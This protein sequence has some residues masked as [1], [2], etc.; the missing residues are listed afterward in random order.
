[1]IA[2][3]IQY[4]FSDMYPMI[5]NNTFLSIAGLILVY[6][7][8]I[9]SIYST[10]KKNNQLMRIAYFDSLT[11]LANRESLRSTIDG[12]TMELRKSKERKDIN[13]A[14]VM[15]KCENLDLIN[16]AFGYYYS[17][18]VLKEIS[19]RIKTL[20]TANIEVFRFTADNFV[21]YIKE[22]DDNK[23][24]IS[25]LE[26]I[27]Q[28]LNEPF[29]VNKISQHVDI[30]IGVTKDK[31]K[32]KFFD[33]LLQEAT[34]ALNYMDAST[35]KNY[36]FYD[37][38]MDSAIQREETIER[39][40]RDAIDSQDI[41]KLYL[42][43]QPIID[44]KIGRI[45]SFEALA[46][47]NSEKYGPVSPGEFIDIAERKQLIIPLT[48]FILKIACAFINELTSLGH[49]DLRV[50]VNISTIHILQGNFVASVLN[51][52][53][54]FGISGE[55]LE[56][57]LTE[58]IMMENFQVVNER[59]KDLRQEGIHISLDDFGTG[60]SSFDRLSELNVD[61]LKIDQYF[62]NNIGE[63]NK[64]SYITR[65]LISIAHKFGLQTVAEGVE[66]DAQRDYLLEYDC[67]KFQG[68]FFSKPLPDHRAIELLEE[69][70]KE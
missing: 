34:I 66:Y 2:L 36:S 62:I 32:D 61:T 20:E 63:D 52:M 39:E 18:K 4:S 3:Y 26:E 33:E 13:R 37:E 65:D 40:L 12:D 60:Y 69:Y 46:R 24:L 6:F 15:I 42:V 31:G 67:D 17:D 29:V 1:M 70:N 22:Y 55:N 49:D 56:L 47:M 9:I 21:V 64:F 14:V 10:Y 35:S 50:A 5:R 25:I 43:Y 58:T 59:L 68:Y 53:K 7:T 8:L 41:S 51:I 11:G 23:D 28:I 45:D 19:N 48:N 16:L 27:R 54:E 30:T 44:S 57:E 38:R